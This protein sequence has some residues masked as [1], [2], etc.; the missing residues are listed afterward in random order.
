[1]KVPFLDLKTQNKSIAAEAIPM[2]TE[3]LENAAFIGGPNVE[4]FEKAF[5]EFCGTRYCIGVNSGI[6]RHFTD[7]GRA[8][9]ARLERDEKLLSWVDRRMDD[10]VLSDA[11]AMSILESRL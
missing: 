1:M 2:F 4:N 3:A 7:S 11:G 6:G 9:C 8:E 5:A 10:Y